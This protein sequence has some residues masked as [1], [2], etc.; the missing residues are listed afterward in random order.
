MRILIIFLFFLSSICFGQVLKQP[1]GQM[2]YWEYTDPACVNCPVLIFLHG[3]GERSS[4][5]NLSK[6]QIHGTPKLLKAAGLTYLKGFTLI[7]PQQLATTHDWLRVLPPAEPDII[8]FTNY[9][10]LNVPN[11]GRVY[12]TGLSM[13][14]RGAFD[15]SYNSFG[16][17]NLITA[18]VP[19]STNGDYK[20]GIETARRKTPTW[21][22]YGSSDTA[23]PLNE[24]RNP[25]NGMRDGGFPAQVTIINGGTHGS[26]TWD[27]AFSLTPRAEIGNTTIYEW[28]LKQGAPI[29]PVPVEPIPL[30]TV[31]FSY[32][33]GD[34][35]FHVGKSGNI[36][37]K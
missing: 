16:N 3:S 12:I 8:K 23:F 35:V 5:P 27:V 10:R 25:I 2:W 6:I 15:A 36:I 4:T 29:I 18:I 30:D 7:C 13:G 28:I 33:K 9:I 14:G 32:I 21:D 11:D 22:I 26:S 31:K 34:S 19:V 1:Q 24:I 37:K 20:G 17:A